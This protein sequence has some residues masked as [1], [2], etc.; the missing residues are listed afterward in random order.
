MLL[1]KAGVFWGPVVMLDR[2]VGATENVEGVVERTFSGE[3]LES[4]MSAKK[5]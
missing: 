5:V 4:D 1:L 3:K 2:R